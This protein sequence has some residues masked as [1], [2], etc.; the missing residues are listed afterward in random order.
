VLSAA[1][2]VETMTMIKATISLAVAGFML[3]AQM[4]FAGPPSPN[5]VPLGVADIPL[6]QLAF[7]AA[8]PFGMGGAVVIAAVSLILGI[9]LIKR[10]K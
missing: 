5:I 6:G 1:D 7:S 3:V 2:S 4:S 10:K 9:Q 8:L